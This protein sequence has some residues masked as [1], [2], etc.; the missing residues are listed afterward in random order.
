MRRVDWLTPQEAAHRL[1]VSVSTVRRWAAADVLDPEPRS[2]RL[3]VSTTSV[4]RHV[5]EESRWITRREAARVL[6]CS[7]YRVAVLLRRGVL[8]SRRVV[9]G[10]PVVF[11]DDVE[12]LAESLAED[13][14]GDLVDNGGMESHA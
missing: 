9:R 8:T 13:L 10:R 12:A 5:A 2:G 11:R 14:A 7:T 1:G 4:T 6:G 3:R